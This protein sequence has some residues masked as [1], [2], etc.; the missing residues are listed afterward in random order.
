MQLKSFC[1]GEVMAFAERTCL[2]SISKLFCVRY[3]S[4]SCAM[5]WRVL[6]SLSRRGSVGG[7]EGMGAVW[8]K[9][10]FTPDCPD[11]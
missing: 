3:S 10:C 9:D 5:C 4:S 2:D 11:T 1:V 6:A 7:T 8:K